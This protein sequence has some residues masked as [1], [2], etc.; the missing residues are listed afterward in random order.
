MIKKRKPKTNEMCVCCMTNI[1]DQKLKFKH[2]FECFI[3]IK[4]EIIKNKSTNIWPYD[5]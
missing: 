5:F 2:E 1:D 4:L 3:F